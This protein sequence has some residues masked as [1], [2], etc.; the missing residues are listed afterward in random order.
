MILQG[1]EG[2]LN[3]FFNDKFITSQP[4]SK[5]KPVSYYV[6]S[7]DA[8]L[9][10]SMRKHKLKLEDMKMIIVGG[11]QKM[12]KMKRYHRDADNDE[13]MML[14]FLSLVK[15]KIFDFDDVCLVMRRK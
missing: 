2:S 15:L 4:L 3:L 5:K 11:L 6:K 7:A 10:Y 1:S 12:I 13:Q 9:I 8:F 14:M